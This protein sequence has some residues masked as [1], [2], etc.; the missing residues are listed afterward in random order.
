MAH[1]RTAFVSIQASTLSGRF[2]DSSSDDPSGNMT[3]ISYYAPL[4]YL[5]KYYKAS[6][7]GCIGSV[8]IYGFRV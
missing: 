8:G 5:Y 4:G 3:T 7:K 6:Y 1:I 2:S